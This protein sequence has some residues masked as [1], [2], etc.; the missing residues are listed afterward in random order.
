[1]TDT[2]GQTIPGGVPQIGGEIVNTFFQEELDRCRDTRSILT[3]GV[4]E[5]NASQ[6]VLQ[7]TTA[8]GV[9]GLHTWRLSRSFETVSPAGTSTPLTLVAVDPATVNVSGD[10][11][12]KSVSGNTWN[13]AAYSQEAFDPSEIDF[14][15]LA[16]VEAT[17]GT[18]REM[19][20][21]TSDPA[22][23]SSFNSQD[24]ALYQINNGAGDQIYENGRFTPSGNPRTPL[25]IGDLIGIRAKRGV[26]DYV[27]VRGG[28]VVSLF[29]SQNAAELPLHFRAA[30]NRGDGSSGESRIENAQVFIGG[31]TETE[32]VQF[33]GR[34]G[35]LVSDADA[36]SLARIGL[37]LQ[38]GSTYD[39]LRY[40]KQDT[41]RYTGQV[42]DVF[43]G[44]GA[45]SDQ[46]S[47]VI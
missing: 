24:Y 25:N 41:G 35:A 45:I 18:I 39:H 12:E 43:H 32:T 7:G 44:Y 15:L 20:G 37:T 42:V 34:A 9:N 29:T 47:L 1:M 2:T 23:N 38:A 11:A 13:A 30:L 40:I 5:L 21:G 14:M 3:G 4:T 46:S 16:Q 10:D 27:I 31:A 8:G 19:V 17:T 22:A 36:A 6:S 33:S 28:A 26:V